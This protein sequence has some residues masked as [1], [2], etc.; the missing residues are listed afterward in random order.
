[1]AWVAPC[2]AAR[3]GVRMYCAKCNVH[4]LHDCTPT[5]VCNAIV[6]KIM[7]ASAREYTVT[8]YTEVTSPVCPVRVCQLS[9]VAASQ[10]CTAV[11]ELPETISWPSGLNAADIT[12]ADWCG[13]CAPSS[14]AR[15]HPSQR[16]KLAPFCQR[17]PTRSSDRPG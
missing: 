4:T 8:L 16:S 1:V 11:S 10:T 2:G 6:G 13:W 3:D 12:M 5:G 15:T 14:S 9:P 7:T 17:S